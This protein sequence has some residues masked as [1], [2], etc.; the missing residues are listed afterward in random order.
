MLKCC[1]FI[2]LVAIF[3]LA[4][5]VTLS[6]H[7]AWSQTARTIRLVVPY[8]PGGPGDILARLLG[9]QISRTQGQAIVI[10]NRPG[11]TGRIGTEAVSRAAPDGA[12]LLVVGNPFI[13][14]PHLQKVSYDPLSS[15]EPICSLTNQSTIIVVNSASPFRTLNDL[16]DAARAKP[17]GVTLASAGPATPTQIAVEML[18]R[19]AHVDLTFVPYAGAAPSVNAVLGAHVTSAL[20]P[21]PVA[22][23][24]LK[25]GKLRALAA[26]SR[27]RIEPL[28]DTPTVAEAGYKDIEA[29]FWIGLVAPAKTPKETLAELAGWFAA[30][31]HVPEVKAKLVAQGQ[32]PVGMCGADFAALLRQQYEDYGRIVREAS[33]KTQ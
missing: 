13:L 14:D 23:E 33:I 16:I 25:A 22:A 32:F 3:T 9:E 29:D 27:R 28:P 15:F 1:R 10:E 17:G 31:L 19:A 4:P 21:Y 5:L 18:K 24:H 8:P 2:G 6:G 26:A 11:A 12:T 20:V 7:G 30:A